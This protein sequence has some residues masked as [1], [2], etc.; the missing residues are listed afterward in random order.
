MLKVFLFLATATIAFFLTVET[1]ATPEADT[2]TDFEPAT[3]LEMLQVNLLV[4]KLP[5]ESVRRLV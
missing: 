4:R 2:Q 5:A 1:P 3:Q